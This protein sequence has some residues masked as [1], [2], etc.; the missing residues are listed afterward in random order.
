VVN[1]RSNPA[2]ESGWGGLGVEGLAGPR[3]YEL[4][5]ERQHQ[6]KARSDESISINIVG[7]EIIPMAS[8]AWTLSLGW[9]RVAVD[10]VA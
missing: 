5:G 3:N 2:E 4:T 6:P 8:Q 7:G 10:S 9:R 1:S